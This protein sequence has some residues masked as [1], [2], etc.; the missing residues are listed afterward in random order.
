MLDRACRSGSTRAFESLVVGRPRGRSVRVARRTASRSRRD[1]VVSSQPAASSITSRCVSSTCPG[2]HRPSGVR[3][4]PSNTG[5]AVRAGLEIGADVRLMDGAWWCST[6]RAPDDPVPRL[7]IMEKSYPGNCVVNRRGARIAN[8]SQ[9]YMGYQHEFFR[10]HTD[11]DP[12]VPSWMC[13]MRAFAARTMRGPLCAD[14]LQARLDDAE[15][16][17]QRPASSPGPTP[18]ASSLSAR[19]STPTVW[20]AR[21][22]R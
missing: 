9:N 15:G 8:E 5:D 13:S 22:R 17:L 18:S 20:S 11:A 7:A 21:S 4:S 3:P 2:P 12:Q 10:R 19:E 6:M 1:A 16:V 14:T